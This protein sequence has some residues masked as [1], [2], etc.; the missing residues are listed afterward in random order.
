MTAQNPT[1]SHGSA[2]PGQHGLYPR[3]INLGG[4]LLPVA[5]LVIGLWLLW[6]T[7]FNWLYLGLLVG[8][9]LV[10]GFGIT[11][12]YHRLFT[13]RSFAT[14]KWVSTL[15]AVMGSMAVEGPV[16][17]WVA[18]HR[19]HHQHSDN[20]DDPHSPHAFGGGMLAMI[21]G[22]W[23]AHVG[24]SLGKRKH[25]DLST[26]VYD[27][28]KDRVLVWTSR[29]FPLW[30]ALGLLVP[31][32]LG[33]L[34]TMSWMGVLLGFLWGG[35][36]RVMVVHHITWSINSVCHI[37]GSTPYK[38]NDESK[39]N[40][41]FGILALGEGWHNNHHAFPRSA[42]HGLAWWQFDISYIIIRAM[43]W[44]GLAKRINVPDKATRESRRLVT[45]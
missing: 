3:L 25:T 38:S 9:Y 12:G 16:L 44:V 5:G 28:K 6:G 29:L 8:M 17:H 24:W 35:L 32:V 10:T 18:V 33:G 13:H 42:R 2:K 7:H 36:V 26:Y 39:N 27:L 30:V 22:M 15:L 37:W 34:L 31:A 4:V 11:I 45:K 43:S 41:V 1:A 20:H 40:V 21:R 23:H 19:K 14:P